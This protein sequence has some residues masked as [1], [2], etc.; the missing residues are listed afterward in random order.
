MENKQYN[1][2]DVLGVVITTLNNIQI[3]AG[4]VRQ[5]GVPISDSVENLRACLKAMQENNKKDVKSD[6]AD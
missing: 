2:K 6:G 1:V 5:I 4:L 3:P